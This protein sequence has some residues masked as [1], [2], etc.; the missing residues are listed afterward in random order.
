MF[1]IRVEE[2]FSVRGEVFF[3]FLFLE[4]TGTVVIYIEDFQIRMV[5]LFNK[6]S[7]FSNWFKI[8]KSDSNKLKLSLQK[9]FYRKLIYLSKNLVTIFNH[10]WKAYFLKAF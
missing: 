2:S 8:S 9:E 1:Q 7:K 5:C 6:I 3:V 10:P 4:T